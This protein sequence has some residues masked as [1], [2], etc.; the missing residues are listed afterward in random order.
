MIREK[1][2]TFIILVCFGLAVSLLILQI[3]KLSNIPDAQWFK[4]TSL[5]SF[6]LLS[7]GMGILSVLRIKKKIE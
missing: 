1:I 2:I 4:N 3:I 5:I 6:F 7:V